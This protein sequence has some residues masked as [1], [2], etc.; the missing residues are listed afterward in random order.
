MF[1]NAIKGSRFVNSPYLML[2]YKFTPLEAE[3]CCGPSRPLTGFIKEPEKS[4]GTDTSLNN[5]L[6]TRSSERMGTN[7]GHPNL[8]KRFAIVAPKSVIKK[9]TGRNLLR[10]RGYSIIQKN[11][12]GVKN[13]V[14]GIFLV[15]KGVEKLKFIEMEKEI[16]GLLKKANILKNV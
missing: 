3:A 14:L 10:R 16:V 13:G 4:L 7:V 11:L 6:R 12:A 5:A 8:T 2:R 9:A 15:K 1:I